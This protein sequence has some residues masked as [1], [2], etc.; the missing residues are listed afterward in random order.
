M[1]NRR[2]IN[3][4]LKVAQAKIGFKG[5]TMA[6]GPAED[7]SIGFATGWRDPIDIESYPWAHLLT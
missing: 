7:G 4:S 6:K 1:F 3:S 2:T 5:V